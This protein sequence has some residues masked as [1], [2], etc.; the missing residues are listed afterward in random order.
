MKKIYLFILIVTC[1]LSFNANA[2]VWNVT[3]SGFTFSPSTVT[4]TLG[5]TVI[6]NLASIHNAIEVSQ[7]TWNANG[8]TSNGGFSVGFGGGMVVPTMVKTYYYVCQPHASSGMKGQI[9]VNPSTGIP[10]APTVDGILKFEPNPAS[11]NTKVHTGLPAGVSGKLT[12]YDITG[13]S[14]FVR[15]RLINDQWIDV[16]S[17]NKGIYI[18]QLES[19]EYKRTAKLVVTR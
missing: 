17:L 14:V 1:A 16:S 12:V 19:T 15:E 6:F 9:I 13:K 2:K 4:I 5:D 8:S 10:S 3:N 7:A 18:V 11:Y